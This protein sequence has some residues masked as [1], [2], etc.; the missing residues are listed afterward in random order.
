MAPKTL[1]WCQDLAKTKN[2]RV[3]DCGLLKWKLAEFVLETK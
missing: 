3:W 2:D 1:Q